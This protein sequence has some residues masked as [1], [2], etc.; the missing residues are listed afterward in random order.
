[1][2][3]VTAINAIPW[4]E[5][6]DEPNIETAVKPLA[7]HIDT[8]IVPR[9][10]TTTAR[11][12]AVPSPIEG[13]IAYTNTHG[14][15]LYKGMWVPMPGTIVAYLYNNGGQSV[16]DNTETPIE[17]TTQVYLPWGGHSLVTNP[18]RFTPPFSGW[19][20]VVGNCT[21]NSGGPAYTVRVTIE[22]NTGDII[23]GSH[24]QNSTDGIGGAQVVAHATANGT[25]DFFE[26]TALHTIG[27]ASPTYTG[28]GA[29]ALK[30]VYC[31][32]DF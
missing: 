21:F 12:T 13:Q 6:T 22:K 30:V 25:T 11:N 24:V 23:G 15:Q 1:M 29:P 27:S 26:L 10:A 5:L 28:P 16:A 19:Y 8:R 2:S 14:L 31:G 18:T 20:E 3:D 4:P 32:P 7:D 9:F 17:M